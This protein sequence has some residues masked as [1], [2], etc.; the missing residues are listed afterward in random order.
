MTKIQKNLLPSSESQPKRREEGECAAP[1]CNP[2]KAIP[3]FISEKVSCHRPLVTLP[4]PAGNVTTARW[5][6]YHRAVVTGFLGDRNG[7]LGD[8]NGN[9][10]V[11]IGFVPHL[12]WCEQFVQ[13]TCRRLLACM[14]TSLL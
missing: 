3:V 9:L 4:P 6:R 11:W 5:Q 1:E 10:G 12:D 7:N 2:M 8:R 14:A 13:A